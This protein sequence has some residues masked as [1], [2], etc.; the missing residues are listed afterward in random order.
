MLLR[1][2]K[3][4]YCRLQVPKVL[5]ERMGCCELKKS[6]HTENKQEAKVAAGVLKGKASAAF[7]RL[8]AGLMTDRELEQLT[9]SI[10][11]EFTGKIEEHRKQR[12]DGLSFLYGGVPHGINPHCDAELLEATF[13]FPRD[14]TT[15]TTCY[16]AWIRSLEEQRASGIYSDDIRRMS[17]QIIGER[18]L[19]VEQPAPDWFDPNGDTWLTT[20]PVAF[21]RVC[22]A[23][24]DGL[25][26]GYRLELDRVQGR[27]S[28]A[29]EAAITARIEAAQPRPKLSDLFAAYRADKLTKQK[30]NR[31]TQE[32]NEEY[33]Q[34]CIDLLGNK[35]LS[36]YRSP[37]VL[38]FIEA[39]RKKGN[40]ADT[41][42]N[43]LGFLS[44]M[45]KH[46]LK[47]PEAIDTWMV[48]GNPFA[49]MQPKA[50][51]TEK[52]PRKPYTFDDLVILLTGL[53]SI[54]K[55]V[56]P[57]RFWVPLIALFSGMRQGEV[58]QLR[59]VDIEYEGNIL[60]FRLRHR[61]EHRQK[62]KWE[63]ERSCPVHPTLVK[64]GFLVFWEG[65]KKA[66]HDRLF[67]TL[68]YTPSKEW[69]GK[70][71][72]WWN[73]SFTAGLLA[74]KEGKSFHSL[75]KNFIDWFKQSEVYATASDRMV[76]QS[77]AGHDNEEDVTSKHYEQ[78]F[79]AATQHKLLCKL[80]YGFDAELI[81][82]LQ[83]K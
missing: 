54:R 65:Q 80:D 63:K 18:S 31:K 36:E 58:C 43:K 2:G 76:M 41:I 9:V 62:M 40:K 4:Y 8:R 61:P 71:R 56:D 12:N 60:I 48:R 27:R 13:N 11:A 79:P 39:L 34:D 70:I 29:T 1:R 21:A 28:S 26:E 19:D 83:G 16:Q 50:S 57:H 59:T 5:Q 23:L 77:M 44:S 15:A 38:E 24:I 55:L 67:H 47:T 66:K 68:D 20:P 3:V 42:K 14:A 82:Q 53:L 45:Y 49:D 6:L 75:R 35:E 17:S 64:L 46:A 37:D 72:S 51:I 74:D 10:L 81:R 32:K 52:K 30:W 78:D 33:Y 69:T 7:F 73:E 22:D 25:I